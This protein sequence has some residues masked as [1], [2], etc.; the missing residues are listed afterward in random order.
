[1]RSFITHL[2]IFKV[3][4]TIAWSQAASV[5]AAAAH[6]PP[7]LQEWAETQKTLPDMAVA[8]QQ[9][10][11]IPALKAPVST[12]GRF[13]RFQDGAFR[14]ELGNPPATVL[15]HDSAEFRVREASGSPWQT[16]EENDARYRMW[17]RFLSGREASPEDLSRH[18]VVR[19]NEDQP[20]VATV[21][22]RPK[23]PFVRRYL[24]QIDL[25]ISRAEK[26][27]LQLR[28]IQG[29]QST[30][31]MTFEKPTSVTAEEKTRLLAR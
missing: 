28:V 18:F 25:Q 11:S 2:L 19:E 15:V 13:W 8:F 5:P 27:L 4:C 10:R 26:R 1:M 17:A 20:G 6:L 3:C 21:T 16:L 14:W 30:L 22:L 31:L 23:A 12:T 29:D 24:R 9:T 7:I